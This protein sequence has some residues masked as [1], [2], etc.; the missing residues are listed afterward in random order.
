MKSQQFK[1]KLLSLYYG[2]PIKDMKLIVVAN[3]S[4]LLTSHFLHEILK[5]AN[6]NV[7]LLAAERPFS[8]SMLHKFLSDAWKSGADFVI[9][10]APKKS[11]EN[12]VFCSLPIYET[13]ES[14]KNLLKSA[15]I[16]AQTSNI[17]LLNSKNYKQGTELTL[18]V[19]SEIL[20][21]ATFATGDQVVP[22]AISAVALAKPLNIPSEN[23][24]DGLANYE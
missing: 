15:K 16:F 6:K 23:I 1:S 3:D 12:D 21:L 2:N 11:L 7:A 18:A 19:N 20:N 14:E 9:T 22:A 8:I 4:Q 13:L 24:T 5:S 10:T 17:K